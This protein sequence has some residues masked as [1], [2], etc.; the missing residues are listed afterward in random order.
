MGCYLSMPMA[1]RIIPKDHFLDD[2]WS[3]YEL[4]SPLETSHGEET[5]HSTWATFKARHRI[6]GEM[7]ALKLIT[8][9]TPLTFAT[10]M[11]IV[12]IMTALNHPNIV[13]LKGI[14]EDQEF[15]CLAT[16]FYPGGDLFDRIQ[17]LGHYS[18]RSASAMAQEIIRTVCYLHDCDICHLDLKPENFAFA[19]V[20]DDRS[21]KLI[22]LS[23]A[24]RVDV[25]RDNY[26]SRG[27]KLYRSPEMEDLEFRRTPAV[28]K[29]ADAYSLGILLYTMLV[30]KFPAFNEA[31]KVVRFPS[32]SDLSPQV[33]DLLT[34]LTDVNY[35]TRMSVHEAL[36]HPWVTRECPSYFPL[37]R[38][39][40]QGLRN[41]RLS[42]FQ[43]FFLGVLITRLDRHR[44][45]L[46]TNSFTSLDLSQDGRLDLSDVCFL[47]DEC[48]EELGLTSIE[49]VRENAKIFF[50]HVQQHGQIKPHAF[51]K[52]QILGCM[53][54]QDPKLDLTTKKIFQLM[55][56]L[57]TNRVNLD[58]FTLFLNVP[59]QEAQGLFESADVNR[60][61]QL[62]LD[63]FSA[64][65]LGTIEVKSNDQN[66]SK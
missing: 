41:Y 63:E 9:K 31:T 28:L 61:G 37:K 58:Q 64:A 60:N 33:K 52:L 66:D 62:S 43:D 16:Q 39:T 30:G 2:I 22:N 36:A 20:N 14:Y 12:N 19:E 27:T 4:I 55:D 45:L 42:E 40:V 3:I 59:R 53:I 7:H 49:S 6:R 23:L 51:F 38:G 1:S 18:E 17:K 47:F 34:R 44:S 11:G 24:L 50:D 46:L 56:T 13:P 26:P 10:F 25:E 48:K 65:L 54:E 21:I 32:V 15:F 57:C 35:Q 5:S 8:K 29:K